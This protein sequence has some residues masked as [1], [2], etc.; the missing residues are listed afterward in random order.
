MKIT[1]EQKAVWEQFRDHG[2]ITAIADANKIDRRIISEALELG[3]AP[4]KVID[5]IHVF[6]LERKKK[7]DARIAE[8]NNDQAA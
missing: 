8:L 2:D 7:N 1:N 5:A 6:Y 4:E 3:E